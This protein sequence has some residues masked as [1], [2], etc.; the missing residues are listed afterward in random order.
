MGPPPPRR[1]QTGEMG[2]GEGERGREKGRWERNDPKG[3]RAGGSCRDLSP[4]LSTMLFAGLG[5]A[6]GVV[7]GGGGAGVMREGSGGGEKGRDG[8]GLV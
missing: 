2:P 8:G 4:A 7:M 6:E 5:A 1:S 3:P